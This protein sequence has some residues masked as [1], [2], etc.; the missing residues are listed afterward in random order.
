MLFALSLA[1]GFLFVSDNLTQKYET[2]GDDEIKRRKRREFEFGTRF[3]RNYLYQIGRIVGIF[4][5]III[6]NKILNRFSWMRL[7]SQ[8][9]LI[10]EKSYPM[11]TPYTSIYTKRCNHTVET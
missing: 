2:D 9:S 3:A 1:N 4:D 7:K 10:L 5:F 8:P 11:F 6:V